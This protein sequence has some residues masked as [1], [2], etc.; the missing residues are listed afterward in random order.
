MQQWRRRKRQLQMVTIEHNDSIAD[1]SD[2]NGITPNSKN[3]NSDTLY[4]ACAPEN[5][6]EFREITRSNDF[7]QTR[8]NKSVNFSNFSSTSSTHLEELLRFWVLNE[9]NVPKS[10]VTNL[11]KLLRT[12]QKDLLQSFKTLLPTPKLQYKRC[13]KGEYVHFDNLTSALKQTL[14]HSISLNVD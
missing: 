14:L 11:L 5:L 13:G 6:M 2:S 10:L 1:S 7:L 3:K 4:H 8:F 9:V 12:F